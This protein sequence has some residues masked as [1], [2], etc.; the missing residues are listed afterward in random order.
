MVLVSG[1]VDCLFWQAGDA[2]GCK[3]Q[4]FG[5]GAFES[6]KGLPNNIYIST[7]I[8]FFISIYRIGIF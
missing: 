4:G 1:A 5:V 6:N 3:D 7:R 2:R 8:T